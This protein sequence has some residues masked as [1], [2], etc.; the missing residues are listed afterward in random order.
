MQSDSTAPAAVRGCF[1]RLWG[2]VF[3]LAFLV[4][5]AGVPDI[6]GPRIVLERAE[7]PGYWRA[8]YLLDGES[9]YLRFQRP[10][11]F[12]RETVWEVVTPGWDV[13]RLDGDQAL[14]AG[15]GASSD[16]VVVEFP[17]YNG[18]LPKEYEFF[19][20]F[21]DGSVAVYTGHLYVTATGEEIPEEEAVYLRRL[22]LVP[23]AEE[24][25][26]V[27]GAASVGRRS[28]EDLDGDGT[29][30]YF[31]S[32]EPLE[33]EEMIAIIDPGSPAWLAERLN[34]LLPEMFAIYRESFGESLPW[35]PV[36]LFNFEDLEMSG[37]SSGGGTLTGLVQMSAVGRAWH[38]A[39]PESR[40]QLLYLIAHEAAHFWNSQMHAYG[41]EDDL[42]IHEGSADAFAELALLR[43]GY[44]DDQRLAA[45]RSE[46]LNRCTSGLAG[47]SL[48]T[49]R[50]RQQ[51]RNYY[52]CGNI[53]A[54]WSVAALGGPFEFNRLFEIW[55]GMFDRLDPE[56]GSYTRD[57]YF[58]S[59]RSL[60]VG[61]SDLEALQ[62]FLDEHHAD[63]S[64]AVVALMER[65][66]IQPSVLDRPLPELRRSRAAAAMRHLMS[67]A[68]DGRISFYTEGRRFR[69]DPVPGC[70]PF[71][72]ELRVQAI[73]G[74][75]FGPGGDLAFAAAAD[76][77]RRGGE[78]VLGLEDGRTVTVDCETPVPPEPTPLGFPQLPGVDPREGE[79]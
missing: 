39:T 71:S 11:A 51:F 54:V 35:K 66:G 46:A 53:L 19:Q 61:A 4:S 29:Y 12:Y 24:R 72:R 2:W 43:A 31:G 59:L 60:G 77:C 38:E 16:R 48:T 25:V 14:V 34:S 15:H 47:G 73:E 21:S 20:S 9:A 75:E 45:R 33:T 79:R 78:V 55:V 42:W 27:R 65:V 28:W 41:G 1:G 23:D 17:E 3:L 74:H 6:S 67:E 8:T 44:I 37:Q 57:N 32:I 68:C 7:R 52:S 30:V 58:E 5:C 13:V 40:E 70:E 10:A 18:F 26:V 62:G 49:S 56:G 64:A 63:P 50:E 76:R 69:T 36:V 22:E